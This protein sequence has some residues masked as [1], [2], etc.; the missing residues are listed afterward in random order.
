MI[1]IV[2]GLGMFVIIRT[3]CLERT[4]WVQQD[5]SLGPVRWDWAFT[6]LRQRVGSTG[7]LGQDTSCT[8]GSQCRAGLEAGSFQR[9]AGQVPF[10]LFRVDSGQRQ[11]WWRSPGPDGLPSELRKPAGSLL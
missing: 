2:Q 3:L 4:S 5:C 11:S 8:T 1:V 7:K 9:E 10:E 6:H